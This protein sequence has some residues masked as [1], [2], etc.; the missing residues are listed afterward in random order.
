MPEVRDL[1]V[2]R[3]EKV[4]VK[5][6]GKEIDVS[7][8]PTGLTF[9]IDSLVREMQTLDSKKIVA[10]DPEESR[11]GFNLTVRLCAAYC[12]WQHPEMDEAWFMKNTSVQ[13]INVLGTAIR[14]A[15]EK[16]YEGIDLKKQTATE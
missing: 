2:L 13:Q 5:L 15:L 7:F 8:V 14:D 4:I 9:D 3:P 11:K 16:A 10:N 6:A 12:Q 1:D